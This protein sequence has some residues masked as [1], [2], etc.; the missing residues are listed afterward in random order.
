[1]R[2]IGNSDLETYPLALGTNSFGW[3]SDAAES[4]KVL[5][6]FTS[7]GG[8]FLDTAD[9]Y[10]FWIPGNSGGESE[11]IIGD[12]MKS[13][14]NRDS[15]IVATKVAGHPQFVGLAPAT[16]A[17]AADASLR[18]LQTDHID[19]YLAHHD[20]E[21]T[22]LVETLTAF[23]ELVDAGKVRYV[24]ISNYTADRVAEW[25]RVAQENGFDLPVALQ[26]PYNLV[27][28]RA[29][30]QTLAPLVA[31]HDLGVFAYPALASGFLTGKYRTAADAETTIR[32]GWLGDYLTAD[33]FGVI[34]ALD[35]VAQA[36]AIS[37]STAALA[38][39]LAKDV[40][41]A[42]LAGAR[43]ADQVPEL[44]AATDVRL[45]DAEVVYLDEASAPFA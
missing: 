28:R 38:W 6:A 40:V 18:R 11:A 3:S 29:F 31:E 7:A 41:T 4:E 34:T 20:D 25:L 35:T 15:V 44:V 16:V 21:S 22:P 43:T 9:S 37:T 27:Q 19:L 42:P 12:W 5:D 30:E 24:G 17:A 1:M 32:G 14:G 45:T 10:S 8:N 23:Q 39:L 33:G 36:H 13:R 2:T 26:P